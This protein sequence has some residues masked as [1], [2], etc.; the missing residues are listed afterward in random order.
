MSSVRIL[1]FLFIEC[2]IC[3]GLQLNFMWIPTIHKV[4][5]RVA[6]TLK[7]VCLYLFGVTFVDSALSVLSVQ[8][9]LTSLVDWN[10]NISQSFVISG[11]LLAYSTLIV[12]LCWHCGT[13]PYYPAKDSRSLSL[14]SPSSL[15][16]CPENSSHLA[17]PT[18]ISV[19]LTQW[20]Q[21]TLLLFLFP[22]M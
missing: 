3:L 13:L 19:S 10:L 7:L 11:S 16:V 12:I 15:M 21:C 8:Q 9:G 2:T 18:L 17:S 14:Y 22:V 6:F 1:W 4:R 20:N 5:F